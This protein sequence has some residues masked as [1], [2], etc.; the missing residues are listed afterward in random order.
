MGKNSASE[1]TAS[2]TAESDPAETEPSG[3][4]RP[5]DDL[6]EL[7]D[8]LLREL[9][10][11]DGAGDEV[12]EPR[13]YCDYLRYAHA[14]AWERVYKGDADAPRQVLDRLRAGRWFVDAHLPTLTPKAWAAVDVNFTLR[15]LYL[16]EDLL[17]GAAEETRLSDRRRSPTEREV[18]R[19]LARSDGEFLRRGEVQA[20][21]SLVKKPGAA[22]VGQILADLYHHHLVLRLQRQAQGA[23]SVSFYALSPRGHELCRRLGLDREERRLFDFSPELQTT[24]LKPE[25]LASGS[26]ARTSPGAV[27]AF[28][29]YR[30]GVGRSTTVARLAPLLASRL[31]RTGED[32]LVID[33]DLDA[34]GLDYHFAPAGLGE[35]R[36]LRGLAYDFHQIPASRRSAWLEKALKESL[37]VLRPMEHL[38]YLPSGFAPDG[39][40][41]AEEECAEVISRLN[42]EAGIEGSREPGEDFLHTLAAALPNAYEKTLIDPSSGF[43]LGAWAATQVLADELFL[44][45][46]LDNAASVGH[47]TVLSNYLKR[48]TEKNN[49]LLARVGFVFMFVETG[50]NIDLEGWLDEYLMSL[51]YA[52]S[53]STRR[54]SVFTV[55][56]DDESTD[57][58][59]T[60][61]P[62]DSL[63]SIE[64]HGFLTDSNDDFLGLS[65]HLLG[66]KISQPRSGRPKSQG[67]ISAVPRPVFQLIST[68]LDPSCPWEWRWISAGSLA[69]NQGLEEFLKTYLLRVQY[70]QS[71]D[72]IGRMLL[73]TVA[74]THNYHLRDLVAMAFTKSTAGRLKLALFRTIERSLHPKHLAAF[75]VKGR[76]LAKPLLPEEELEDDTTLLAAVN[77]AEKRGRSVFVESRSN[78]FDWALFNGK[79]VDLALRLLDPGRYDPELIEDISSVYTVGKSVR[80]EG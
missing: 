69:N 78:C 64:S 13:L 16:A 8:Q 38:A 2:E 62:I 36:G 42:A 9:E 67:K 59:T 44:C 30:G 11:L 45:G 58:G 29:A 6:D 61:R 51:P 60:N 12:E 65:A 5:S 23:A 48:W 15:S 32:V 26:R 75:E 40:R 76:H 19:V 33:F 70:Q 73:H 1:T 47:R 7:R 66:L 49:E 52:R 80:R 37:Y 41:Q 14:V 20:R 71:T 77:E 50:T 39:D 27:A 68:M 3:K 57:S 46:R 28:Y 24:Y 4:R 53:K 55:Y 35:C 21:L 17:K 22:R 74:A 79:T 54:Y 18:L 72:A 63:R 56:R 31:G 34:P 43:S 25:L 10:R